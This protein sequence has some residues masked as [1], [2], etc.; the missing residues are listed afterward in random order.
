LSNERNEV[1]IT[2]MLME[3]Q[4][5]VESE[6]LDFG[7]IGGRIGSMAEKMGKYSITMP[8]SLAEAAREVS[9]DAGL[10]AYIAGAVEARVRHDKLGQFLAEYEESHEPIT[11]EEI[12]EVDREM[13]RAEA[14]RAERARQ[15]GKSKKA[16]AA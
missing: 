13:A 3:T 6:H 1:D 10:S 15:S 12:D 16:D 7:R 2:A 11:Q 4:E 5:E 14:D 8:R 9:G